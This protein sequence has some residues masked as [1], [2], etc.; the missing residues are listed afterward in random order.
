MSVLFSGGSDSTLAAAIMCKRFE[1]VHLLTFFHSGINFP[2]NSRVN[3]QRLRDKFGKEKFTHEFIDIEGVLKKI[4]Y[5]TYLRDLK[6]YRAYLVAATCSACQLAMHTET[7]IYNVENN[8]GFACDGYKREKEHVYVF[9]EKEGM[10]YTKEFY[11]GYGIGYLN[12]VYDMVRTDWELYD[13][14]IIPKR[15]VKFPHHRLD[16]VTEPNC[17]QGILTNAYILGYHYPLNHRRDDRW[18]EYYKEKILIAKRYINNY[19]SKK[20]I[21]VKGVEQ[22][23]IRSYSE[24]KR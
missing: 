1:K 18:V 20:R 2:E 24:G 6:R 19:L 15:N 11:Q 23:H 17:W 22:D 13:L 12:P 21:A 8:I 7:I 10:K 16:I 3:M 14:G 9:M 4:Y 5:G